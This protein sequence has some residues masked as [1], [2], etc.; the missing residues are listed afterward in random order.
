[1]GEAMRPVLQWTATR[2]QVTP[3]RAAMM[4]ESVSAE[5]SAIV[6]LG[7]TTSAETDDGHSVM[8]CQSSPEANAESSR[9]WSVV[10]IEKASAAVAG[11]AWTWTQATVGRLEVART[12]APAEVISPAA[13]AGGS[14]SAVY[15]SPAV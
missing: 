6:P 1:M 10:A 12:A 8:P 14:A 2:L 15:V 4:T 7:A 13:G 11:S 3:T 5:S 9:V